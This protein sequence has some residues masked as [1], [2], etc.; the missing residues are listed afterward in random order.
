VDAALVFERRV[1][2]PVEE[3][4]KRKEERG[5]RKEERGGRGVALTALW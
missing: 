5:K 3:R 4:G 1:F 2:V